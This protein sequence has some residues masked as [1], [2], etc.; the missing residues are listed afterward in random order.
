[1][2]A[3]DLW[4]VIA[5]QVLQQAELEPIL[6]CGHALNGSALLCGDHLTQGVLCAA[7]SID[8][9]HRHAAANDRC[10]DCGAPPA[11]T[12]ALLWEREVRGREGGDASLEVLTIDGVR[13][14]DFRGLAI[15]QIV[16]VCSRCAKSYPE[17]DR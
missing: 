5:T 2:T 6:A 1:M 16:T 7:C 8:H 13:R 11:L 4:E 17:I 15:M 9:V 10:G 14:L 3:L 12:R